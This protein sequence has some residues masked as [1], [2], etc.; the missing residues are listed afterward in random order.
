MLCD[1]ENYLERIQGVILEH[2]Y[3]GSYHSTCKDYMLKILANHPFNAEISIIMNTDIW[4]KYVNYSIS[5]HWRGFGESHPEYYDKQDFYCN[6]QDGKFYIASTI[7][8]KN[9]PDKNAPV[10]RESTLEKIINVSRSAWEFSKHRHIDD[11]SFHP[12][13]TCEFY[14]YAIDN[15]DRPYKPS[16]IDADFCKYNWLY[17]PLTFK[18]HEI[19]SALSTLNLRV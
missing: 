10:W 15:N 14:A 11:N 8:D 7:D 2:N 3:D 18:V 19:T 6:L 13:Q 12:G 9:D 17:D 1:Y 5:H 16:T 4:N